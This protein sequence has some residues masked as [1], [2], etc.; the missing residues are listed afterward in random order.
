M[1]YNIFN[2]SF[3]VIT[4]EGFRRN[5]EKRNVKSRTPIS[6]YYT[7]ILNDICLK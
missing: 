7:H 6:F 4:A 1:I 3:V 5:V 2:S